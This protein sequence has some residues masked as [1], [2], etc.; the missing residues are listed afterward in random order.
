MFVGFRLASQG[1]T[2]SNFSLAELERTIRVQKALKEFEEVQEEK[3]WRS[4]K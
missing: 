2:H 3:K 4:K 1:R